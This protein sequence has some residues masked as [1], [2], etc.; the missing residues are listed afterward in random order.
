[1]LSVVVVVL[2][3]YHRKVIYIYTEEQGRKGERER[4]REGDEEGEREKVRERGR[5]REIWKRSGIRGQL[6]TIA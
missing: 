4:D 2:V 5:G 1:M 6:V 3:E